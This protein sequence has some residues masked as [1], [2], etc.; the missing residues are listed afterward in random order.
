MMSVSHRLGARMFGLLTI[1]LMASACASPPPPRLVPAAQDVPAGTTRVA[2]RLVRNLP[3]LPVVIEGSG[4]FWFVLDTGAA[5]TVVSRE[6]ADRLSLQPAEAR[7]NVIAADGA[8]RPAR[9]TVHL[10]SLQVGDAVFRSWHACVLDL[11]H[12]REA[13]GRVDGILGYGTFTGCRLVVDYPGRQVVVSR[14][15]RLDPDA[16]D[17]VPVGCGRLPSV[18]LP[19]PAGSTTAVVVDTGSAET[20]AL[21]AGLEGRFAFADAPVAGHRATTIAGT[22][23]RDQVARLAGDVPLCGHVIRR[24]LVSLT[25]GPPRMGGA[26]LRH[27]RVT[28]DLESGLMR[29]ERGER[30]PIETPGYRSPGIAIRPGPDGWFIHDVLP[31]SAAAAAG[32]EVGDRVASIN[33][34]PT[35]ELTARR[36]RRFCQSPKPLELVLLRGTMVVPI[37]LRVTDIVR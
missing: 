17:V 1:L 9:P 22:G 5:A 16:V 20:L 10:G 4:P 21:P 32:L 37:S 29:L 18:R 31:G 3:L 14:G 12:L 2:M 30:D 36:W 34:L 33:G 23:A 26:L 27:F 8:A 35:S 6:L 25:N 19:L 15:P 11:Q 7:V 24:P 13:M 28:F